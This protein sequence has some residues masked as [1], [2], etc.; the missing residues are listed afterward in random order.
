MVRNY[1]VKI[2]L[3]PISLLYGLGVAIRN[4]L[5]EHKVL[6]AVEF[7]IPVISV[8][9][10]TVGGAGKT[11]HIEYLIELLKDYIYVATLSRGYKR[12]TKGFLEVQPNYTA[13]HSGDEPIQFKR[14]YPEIGV[15]VNESR[16]FGVPRILMKRP[17]TQ[18]ILLDDAYQ[19]LSV[20]PGKNILLT[21]YD[22]LFTRDWLLPSGR[23][24]EWR[25]AYKRAHTIIV[26]KCPADLTQEDADIVKR[27]I[28]PK[29]SQSL[30][31]SYFDYHVPYH[32]FD[33]HKRLPLTKD[34]DVMLISGIARTDYLMQYLENQVNSIKALEYEDHHDYTPF[35][36]GQI[37]L[38]F[39]AVESQRKVVLTTEKDAIRLQTH[40]DFFE[41]KNIDIYILPVKV[42]FHL[43]QGS[44]FDQEIKDFLLNFMS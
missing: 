10:L 5:Y 1:L 2:L 9:N 29:A 44:L 26:S 40:K 37:E 6:N 15:F 16:M 32:M 39:N 33:S 17:Q 14:K 22:H 4:F 8:G 23:L 12:K 42:K 43:D 25:S 19:H 20:Q 18:A 27:E 35:D 24:R 28:N 36:V 3:L 41:Q 11:P 34:L 30:Y 21:E 38:H 7:S 13:A 31:F